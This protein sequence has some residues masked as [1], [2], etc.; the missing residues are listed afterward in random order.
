MII[1]CPLSKVNENSG[2]RQTT[3]SQSAYFYYMNS[4]NCDMPIVYD[5]ELVDLFGNAVTKQV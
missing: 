5:L 2:D 4:S 3:D 1:G